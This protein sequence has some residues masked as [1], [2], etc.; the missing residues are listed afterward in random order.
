MNELLFLLGMTIGAIS[1]FILVR[2]WVRRCYYRYLMRRALKIGEALLINPD[3]IAKD[4]EHVA[5]INTGIARILQG[6]EPFE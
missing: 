6:R 2:R 3:Q 5:K 4:M 1:S